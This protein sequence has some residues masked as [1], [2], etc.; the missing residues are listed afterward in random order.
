MSTGSA[1]SPRQ[2]T[3]SSL[4]CHALPAGALGLC[5]RSKTLRITCFLCQA[6]LCSQDKC[7]GVPPNKRPTRQHVLPSRTSTLLL[8]LCQCFLIQVQHSVLLVTAHTAHHGT[9]KAMH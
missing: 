9:C 1:V 6:C 2:L 4:H 7:M 8:L 3:T 5:F